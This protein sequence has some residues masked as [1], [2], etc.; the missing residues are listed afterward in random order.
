[1]TKWTFAAE[2]Q[3]KSAAAAISQLTTTCVGPTPFRL[4]YGKLFGLILICWES[5]L[6]A[7]TSF[8]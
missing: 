2:L 4:R 6:A 8:S 3:Q 1:M 7:C 5:K